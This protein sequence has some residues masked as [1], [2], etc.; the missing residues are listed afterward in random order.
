MARL[1]S[2]KYFDGLTE[3]PQNF[4]KFDWLVTIAGVEVEMHTQ[5]EKLM[6]RKRETL[7][8]EK[9]LKQPM[10]VEPPK[11][12]RSPPI[13][14]T[15]T[16]YS[17]KRKWASNSINDDR[18]P[19]I[20]RSCGGPKIIFQSMYR[21]DDDLGRGDLGCKKQNV[22]PKDKVKKAKGSTKNSLKTKEPIGSPSTPPKYHDLPD[23]FK[24]EIARLEGTRLS[25]VIQKP[26]TM[27]DVNQ[28]DNRLSMP[29]AQIVSMDF[30]E[31]AEKELLKENQTMS[32]QLIDPGLVKGGINLR[33]WHMKKKPDKNSSKPEKNGSKIYVLRTQWGAVA[34]RNKLKPGQLV[35]VWSF[36]VN[37][38]LY[39]ALV[40]VKESRGE[41]D[42]KESDGGHSGGKSGVVEG[43]TSGS[44]TGIGGS[45][46][47][48][49]IMEEKKDDN[50]GNAS[51]ASTVINGSDHASPNR[52]GSRKEDADVEPKL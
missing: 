30:L 3:W 24:R 49:E 38:A 44:S 41:G 19:K 50:N 8:K 13:G 18:A 39:L 27:T 42:H 36:R 29:E 37:G 25:L 15:R 17:L 2:E 26:L 34:K 11:K 28:N 33:R 40:L 16:D 51:G 35:Q 5:E 48:S 7:M 45:G 47:G 31:G 1:L 6:E 9:A 22:M 52:S 4:T 23:E 12:Q 32:V 20:Q 10:L 46:G 21:G 14:S 43:E